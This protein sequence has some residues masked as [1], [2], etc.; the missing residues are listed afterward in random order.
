MRLEEFFRKWCRG[1]GVKKA[2]ELA[3]ETRKVLSVRGTPGTPAVPFAPPRM[4]TGNLRGKIRVVPTAHGARLVAWAPYAAPL[5]K[6][7]RWYGWPHRFLSVA[8][9]RLGLKGRH[10]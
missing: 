7:K 5:E 10:S 6:S 8:M 3:A 1:R 9:A 2:E 4:I